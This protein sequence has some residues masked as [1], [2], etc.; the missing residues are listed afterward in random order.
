MKKIVII[1]EALGGGVRRHIL[2]LLKNLDKSEFE[3][4]FIY[5]L[6]RADSIMIAELNNLKSLG[7]RLIE[8][9]NF[10]REISIKDFVVFINIYRVLKKINPHIVHCHSSKAGAI[11]RVAAKLLRTPKII[12]TPHAYIF[13]NPNLNPYKKIVYKYLEKLL[14]K[15]ATTLTVNVSKGERNF[16]LENKIGCLEDFI[17]IYNGVEEANEQNREVI[18]QNK[19]NQEVFKVI[20]LARVDAQKDPFSFIEIAQKVCKMHSNVR[21]TYVGEGGLLSKCKQKV[22]HL[23]LNENIEFIG[24]S[25]NV[26][27]LIAESH[28]CLSTSLYEGM[29]YSLIEVCRAGLP[30]IASNVIGNNEIVLSEKNGFL[31]D[32]YDTDQAANYILSLIQ[33]KDMLKTMR[34]NAISVYK[35]KYTLDMMIKKYESI[36]RD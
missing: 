5:N 36:Y 30:I 27:K 9:E 18:A 10:N 22:S 20:N 29:P 8:V 15:Y 26:E 16:A 23:G 32:L 4:Y 12:Y 19:D 25:S 34:E 31:F 11:G 1:S 28:I 3:M 2:D 17:I 13:Q 14:N 21:F 35:E 24:F 7:I 6:D 33:D